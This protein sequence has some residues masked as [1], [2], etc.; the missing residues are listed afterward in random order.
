LLALQLAAVR[1]L[2]AH[3]DSSETV[4][5]VT[6]MAELGAIHTLAAMLHSSDANLA[7]MAARA[8]HNIGSHSVALRDA[9]VQTN[10]LKRVLEQSTTPPALRKEVEFIRHFERMQQLPATLPDTRARLMSEDEQLQ[11][12]AA[13]D[14]RTLMDSQPDCIDDV[15]ACEG[16]VER[17]LQ[18]LCSSSSE[19]L[20]V[21]SPCRQHVGHWPVIRCQM[22]L[23]RAH[24]MCL[25][26]PYLCAAVRT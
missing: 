9:I 17:L 21:R 15:I 18:L 19:D 23:S 1:V 7:V 22:L 14:I 12:E 6:A 20:L 26:L 8:L 10:V 4:K 13:I 11:L 5:N 24:A 25:H 16:V 3:E 2:M